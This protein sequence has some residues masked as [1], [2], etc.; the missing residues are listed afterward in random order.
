QINNPGEKVAS[1]TLVDATASYPL[2]NHWNL[3]VNATNLLDKEYLSACDFYCYWG[4]SRTVDAQFSCLVRRRPN[5][6]NKRPGQIPGLFRIQ[7][8]ALIP[9]VAA[10]GSC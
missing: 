8:A 3:Q 6:R 10:A 2:S 9:A 1:Y 5:S 7:D 4:T